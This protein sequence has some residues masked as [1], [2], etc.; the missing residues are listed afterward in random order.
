[1]VTGD[2]NECWLTVV[3][4]NESLGVR[5]FS[6][7]LLFADNGFVYISLLHASNSTAMQKMGVKNKT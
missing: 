3:V 5:H 4:D 6:S 1:M 2:S 7:F